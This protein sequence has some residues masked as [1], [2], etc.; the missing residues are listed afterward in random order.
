MRNKKKQS[1]KKSTRN[2]KRPPMFLESEPERSACLCKCTPSNISVLVITFFL[3]T[4]GFSS[5]QRDSYV[6]HRHWL[7]FNGS[8]ISTSTLCPFYSDQ[9]DKLN[10]GFQQFIFGAGFSQGSN[11]F[12]NREYKDVRDVFHQKPLCACFPCMI[13]IF[14]LICAPATKSW[15][16]MWRIFSRNCTTCSRPWLA[17]T[18]PR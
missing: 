13:C 9:Q 6:F 16:D 18:L 5:G 4:S 8:T 15:E 10:L 14:R 12:C 17:W 1:L 2:V 3:K 11:D 7:F